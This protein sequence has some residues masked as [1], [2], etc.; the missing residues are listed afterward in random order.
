MNWT[1]ATVFFPAILF[2]GDG[3]FSPELL[4]LFLDRYTD[5][6]TGWATVHWDDSAHTR[7]RKASVF[8]GS[9]EPTPVYDKGPDEYGVY[10]S[11]AVIIGYTISCG[12]NP[13]FL[14][15]IAN[16]PAELAGY[17][18]GIEIL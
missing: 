9:I 14:E 15:D 3:Q 2:N 7:R 11:D 5:P 6:E 16:P 18:A 1:D 4:D 17:F 8:D 10:P 13:Q 12:W